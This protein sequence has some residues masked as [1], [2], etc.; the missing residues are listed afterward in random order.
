MHEL[1]NPNFGE[2]KNKL[3]CDQKGEYNLF[4]QK[5]QVQLH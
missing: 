4:P 2:M 1:L 3:N 5:L